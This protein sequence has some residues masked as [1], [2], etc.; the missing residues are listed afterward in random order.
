MKKFL[1][2][3]LALVYLIA[4]VGA[5]IRL[6]YCMNKLVAW[7]LGHEKPHKHACSY[8]GM[9]K[10]IAKN[11]GCCKDDQKQ[12]K[13]EDAQQLNE[14]AVYPAK[15]SPETIHSV[16]PD[17]SFIYVPSLTEVFPVTHAPPQIALVPLFVLNCSY[18]I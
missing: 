6:H 1:V 15:I 18:R 17:Y 13:L 2:T 11:K 7:G 16:F 5:T 4:S 12:I 9:S 8:C 3:I 14:A 10:S